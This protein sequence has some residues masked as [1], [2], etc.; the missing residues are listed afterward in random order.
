MHTFDDLPGSRC[1]TPLMVNDAEGHLRIATMLFQENCPQ[2][3]SACVPSQ[4]V[5]G[6]VSPPSS[7]TFSW[8]ACS[9]AVIDYFCT[10]GFFFCAF[11]PYPQVPYQ[12]GHATK[13]SL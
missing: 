10:R 11:Y 7:S 13:L 8:E 3:R 9:H 12:A 1:A 4:L 5:L 6:I 2:R